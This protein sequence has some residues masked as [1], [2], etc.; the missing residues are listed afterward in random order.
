MRKIIVLVCLV[1]LTA[2]A[3]GPATPEPV[4]AGEPVAG[5]SESAVGMSDRSVMHW[6]P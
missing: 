3:C 2:L 4:T 6:T 5:G 1:G